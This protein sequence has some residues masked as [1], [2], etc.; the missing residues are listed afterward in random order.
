MRV[1]D[2]AS[3]QAPTRD[4]LTRARRLEQRRALRA[5][6]ARVER[7]TARGLPSC[8]QSERQVLDIGDVQDVPDLLSSPSPS[9]VREGVAPEVSRHPERENPL[10]DL[11]HLSRTADDAEANGDV[12][13]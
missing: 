9:L 3:V 11:A 12:L 1:G 7:A 8:Q 4:L 6:A 13:Q 10:L 5:S 2:R